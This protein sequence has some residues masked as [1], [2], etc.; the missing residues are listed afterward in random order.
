MLYFIATAIADLYSESLP[1]EWANLM[2]A[3]RRAQTEAPDDPGAPEWDD[4][5][6]ANMAYRE[7]E[8]A[9]DACFQR[10]W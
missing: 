2:S 1:T 8:N 5:Y 10:T 9:W 6:V 3:L 4:F 7:V